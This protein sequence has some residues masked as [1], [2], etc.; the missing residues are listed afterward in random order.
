MIAA[1]RQGA[2]RGAVLSVI[3]ALRRKT[4]P[5]GVT[6]SGQDGYREQDPDPQCQDEAARPGARPYACWLI[7]RVTGS[8]KASGGT[9]WLAQLAVPDGRTRRAAATASSHRPKPR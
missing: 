1:L 8:W 4:Q 3:S 7:S 6:C 9:V 5:P 2:A